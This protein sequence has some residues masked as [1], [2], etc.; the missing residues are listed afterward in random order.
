MKKIEM[1][2]HKRKA[3][4]KSDAKK[5][6]RDGDIP[7]IIYKKGNGEPVSIKNADVQAMLRTIQSGHLPTTL[8]SLSE[9]K[10]KPR[11]AIVKEI[12]YH[13]TT[14]NVLHLDFE[15]LHDNVP[16]TVKVPVE[17]TGVVDCIGIKLGGVVRQPMRH[18]RVRCLPKDIPAAFEIDIKEMNVNDS[19]KVSDLKI[20]ESVRPLANDNDVI[21]VIVK[22]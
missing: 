15:E 12:Q 5:L 18:V 3:E 9:G 22:R 2:M 13:P 6:R 8:I 1:S 20:P 4:R 16:V 11:L 19:R 10:G 7:A 21:A 17:F 14:Y